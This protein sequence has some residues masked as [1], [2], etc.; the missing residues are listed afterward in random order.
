MNLA[1]RADLPCY[2]VLYS[3]ADQANPTNPQWRAISAFRIR[4]VWP[5]SDHEWRKLTPRELADA[6]LRVRQWKVKQLDSEAAMPASFVLPPRQFTPRS[7]ASR[8]SFL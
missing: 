2:R 8:A 4:R 7:S 1:R 5:N 6:L 3:L